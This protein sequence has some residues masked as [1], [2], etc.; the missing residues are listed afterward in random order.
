LEKH[1]GIITIG[2]NHPVKETADRLENTLHQKGVTIFARID[3]KAEA[4][5]AALT[6]QPMELLIFG[7]PKAGTPVMVADPLSGLDLPLKVLVWEDNNNKVWLTYNDFNYLAERYS[8]PNAIISPLSSVEK[9]IK[10]MVL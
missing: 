2:S 10:D 6:M 7:N 8:L 3:Q 5:K 9:L 4:E 1:F